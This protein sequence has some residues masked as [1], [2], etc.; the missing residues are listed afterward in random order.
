MDINNNLK[1]ILHKNMIE[2]HDNLMNFA[3]ESFNGNV[4]PSDIYAFTFGQLQESNA[5]HL[6]TSYTQNRH[7]TLKYI[8]D[9]IN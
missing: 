7:Q 1:I 5:I 2:K 6:N 3:R 8:L 9:A 4:S